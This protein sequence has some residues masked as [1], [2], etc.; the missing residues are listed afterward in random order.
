MKRF[1][2]GGLSA[3]LPT[4]LTL[5]IVVAFVGFIGDY[6]AAPMTRFV[7]WSLI[8]NRVGH[9]ILEATTPVKVFDERFVD[10]RTLDDGESPT[11]A[12]AAAKKASGLFL[13]LSKIDRAKLYA[14]LDDRIPPVFGLA[15]GF[16]LI[17][18]VGCLFRGVVGRWVFTLAEKLL[19]KFPLVRSIYPW[20]K[21]IVEFFFKDKRNLREFQTVVAVPYPRKGMFT[22]GFV[23]NDGLRSLNAQTN[24]EFVAVF[25]PSSPTPMTGY[26]CFVDKREVVPLTLSLDQVMGILVSGGV[27]VPEEEVVRLSSPTAPSPSGPDDVDAAPPLTTGLKP[28]AAAPEL[29]NKA[30]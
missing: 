10:L 13:D 21:Q 11:E 8:T 1:F 17:F 30:D 4:I 15:I 2:M 19:F 22:L 16:V 12:L 23:T 5:W 27:I 20:A 18:A 24:G 9:D 3:L 25:L 28:A 14:A 29:A 26:I 7:H 6:V